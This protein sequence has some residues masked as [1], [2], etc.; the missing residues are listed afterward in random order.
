M[1]CWEPSGSAPNHFWS[2]NKYAMVRCNWFQEKR[3]NM[4][5]QNLPGVP[6]TSMRPGSSRPTG[7]CLSNG[8]VSPFSFNNKT[9]KQSSTISKQKPGTLRN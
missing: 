9:S 1:K 3:I 2:C 6:D 4:Y 5:R 8:K 7:S